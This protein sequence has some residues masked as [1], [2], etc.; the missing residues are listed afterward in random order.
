MGIA[1]FAMGAC[2]LF[3]KVCCMRNKAFDH[4]REETQD[5]KKALEEREAAIAASD[6]LSLQDTSGSETVEIEAREAQTV[7][8][9]LEMVAELRGLPKGAAGF[10]KL[11]FSGVDISHSSTLQQAGLCNGAQFSVHGE[12]EASK[13]VKWVQDVRILNACKAHMREVQD[14][15]KADDQAADVARDIELVLAAPSQLQAICTI[16]PEKV[17]AQDDMYD[18]TPLHWAAESNKCEVAQI[19][20]TAKASVNSR[21]QSGLCSPLHFACIHKSPEVAELLLTA[22]ADPNCTN[23]GWSTPYDVAKRNQESRE[24]NPKGELVLQLLAAAK[25]KPIDLSFYAP[26]YVQG[27]EYV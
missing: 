6:P 22:G 7:Y 8:E 11:K 19:L 3:C 12:E 2:A 5:K 13:L 10:L 4:G 18:A 1:S 26:I 21:K 16:Y 14:R 24:R 27:S 9:F 23:I 20:L 17:N 25:D 15:E